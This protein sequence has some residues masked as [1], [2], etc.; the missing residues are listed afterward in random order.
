VQ[1]GSVDVVI[2]LSTPAA[3]AELP[4]T[5]LARADEVIE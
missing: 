5:I 2:A 4:T 3:L 1:E